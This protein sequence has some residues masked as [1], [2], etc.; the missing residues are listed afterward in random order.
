[1]RR[2]V[3]QAEGVPDVCTYSKVSRLE[4]HLSC[5]H[6]CFKFCD[7]SD[8]SSTK[9]EE[10][11]CGFQEEP[12]LFDDTEEVMQPEEILR[13]K[14]NVPRSGKIIQ[15]YLIKFKHYSNDDSKCM[16][17]TQMQDALPLLQSY[18]TLH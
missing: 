1:M 16:Q 13:Q 3:H 15:R 6:R 5:S 2:I 18:K 9:R 7:R 12:S 11:G 14:K 8:F 4:R 17:E 10:H